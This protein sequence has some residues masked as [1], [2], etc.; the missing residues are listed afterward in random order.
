MQTLHRDGVALRYRK[1]SGGNGSPVVL[2]HGWCCDHTCFAP[3]FAHFAEQGHTVVAMDLRGHG[4]SDKPDQPYPIGVFADDVVWMCDELGLVRPLLIGHSM[5]GI[6]AFDIAARYPHLPSAVVMLDSA[7]VLPSGTRAAIPTLLN[8]LRGGN[9]AAVLREFISKSLLL[10]T[11]DA[12]RKERLL[13]GMAATPQ[14]VMVAAFEGL[15]A[16]DASEHARHIIAPSLYIAANEP[17]PRCDMA[18]LRQL[19]PSLHCGQT[20][21]SGHFCQLEVPEEINAMIDR[22]LRISGA[23]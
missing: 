16:Y 13:D 1:M 11:D 18:R 23:V 6:A 12:D 3:Q 5:G 20:V 10:P 9:Y 7:V 8:V 22:F 14:Y 4:A 17:Q 19:V 2:I 15:Y 21:G